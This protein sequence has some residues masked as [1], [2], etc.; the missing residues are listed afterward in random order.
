[1][2]DYGHMEWDGGWWIAMWILMATFWILLV[3][4]AVALFVA[5]TGDRSRGEPAEQPEDTLARRLASGEIDEPTY[6]RLS[7]EIAGRHAPPAPG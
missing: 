2:M 4:G 6:H 5:L 1:M 3:G 7:D